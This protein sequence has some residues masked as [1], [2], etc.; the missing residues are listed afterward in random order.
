MP[1]MDQIY[2]IQENLY[3]GAFWPKLNFDEFKK[4][5]ITAIV[6]LMEVSHYDPT[7]MGFK[8]LHKGFPDDRYPPHSY[9]KEILEFIDFN[10]K[11]GGKVLIHCAMAISRSGGITVAWLLKNHSDWSWNDALNYVRKSRLIYPAIEIKESILD[12][13]ESLEGKRRD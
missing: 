2:K 1:E 9:I 6:N 4:F 11:N 10:I 7:P 3:I 12:Y 13:F 5:G 8:Y